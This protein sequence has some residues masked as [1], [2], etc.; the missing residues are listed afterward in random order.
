[1]KVIVNIKNQG[2]TETHR[3]MIGKD[4]YYNPW[5]T[6]PTVSKDYWRSRL[7]SFMSETPP[8]RTAGRP[9]VQAP[10]RKTDRI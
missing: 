2:I 5:L 8:C 9:M 6:P 3:I 7:Q 10:R 1:M 4:A